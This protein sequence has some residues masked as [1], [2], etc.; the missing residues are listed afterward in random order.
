MDLKKIITTFPAEHGSSSASQSHAQS[1]R[2]PESPQN[3]L[4]PC[5]IDDTGSS[6]TAERRRRDSD[7]SRRYRQRRR[8]QKEEIRA[9]IKQRDHYRTERDFFLEQLKVYLPSEQL[10]SRP[11]TPPLDTLA[12]RE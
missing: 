6:R 1:V 4:I 7:A 11:A 5:M 3:S 8:E 12:V 2:S 9:L 10:P